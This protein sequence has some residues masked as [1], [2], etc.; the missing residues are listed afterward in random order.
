MSG[1]S[2]YTPRYTT[3]DYEQW[4]G[5]WELWD[6]TPVSMSPSPSVR[7]QRVAGR[8]YVNLLNQLGADDTCH[9]EVLYEVDWRVKDDTV[10]RPDLLIVCE[11]VDTNWIE[12]TPNL[13][14]EI[15]SP[16]T[17]KNDRDYKRARYAQYGVSYYL[18]VDPKP[19]TIEALRLVNGE[20]REAGLD[21]ISLH[22][23]CEL[24]L[25]AKAIW[26]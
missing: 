22:D 25:D 9:C 17:E 26:S 8:L 15:V 5:D 10:L 7:H 4:Q 13:I 20:Y 6:G 19:Q 1:G 16:G 14:V 21:G 24:S 3:A 2:R 11:P 12:T 18:I 23:G